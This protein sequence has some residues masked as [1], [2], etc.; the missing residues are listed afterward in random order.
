MDRGGYGGSGLAPAS[1]WD[2]SADFGS[3]SLLD[4]RLSASMPGLADDDGSLS[5]FG[6]GGGDYPGGSGGPGGRQGSSGGNG[7]NGSRG[8]HAGHGH[9]HGHSHPNGGAYFGEHHGGS[10]LGLHMSNGTAHDTFGLMGGNAG[11]G[12][13]PPGSGGASSSLVGQAPATSDNSPSMSHLLDQHQGWP[14]AGQGGNHGVH[15]HDAS[16]TAS[17]NSGKTSTASTGAQLGGWS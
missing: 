3:L 8:G 15:H 6:G 16:A 17:S 12:G 4:S 2:L 14:E 13:A 11:S 9:G 7:G 1:G 10:G 5:L